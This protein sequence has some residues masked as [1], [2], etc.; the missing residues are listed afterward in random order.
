MSASHIFRI[1]TVLS[2]F[3]GFYFGGALLGWLVLPIVRLWTWKSALG[4]RRCQRI[5][6]KSFRLM[7]WYVD[8]AGV[9]APRVLSQS[10]RDLETIDLD[11]PAVVVANHPCLL[12]VVLLLGAMKEGVVVVKPW[13]YFNPLLGG[14]AWCCGYIRGGSG[15]ARGVSVI[16]QA[17]QRVEEG[18]VV[19][20]F[21]EGTR[22]PR[23]G[24][25]EFQRGAFRIAEL[26]GA[27]I[28][29]FLI[30]C[31]P[32]VLGKGQALRGFPAGERVRFE[33]HILW[34]EEPE[35]HVEDEQ[36]CAEMLESRYREVLGAD[37][38]WRSLE[39]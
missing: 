7:L 15:L 28:A 13:V 1:L 26:T 27:P 10:G 17:T 29:P 37:G 30:R 12:D 24:L 14:L 33:A 5:V 31:S 25:H 21:P 39:K 20:L 22:S 9:F 23:H 11:E 36:R 35:L 3:V 2:G 32:P 6:C 19:V 34:A 18:A 38:A 4:R 16:R 8:L